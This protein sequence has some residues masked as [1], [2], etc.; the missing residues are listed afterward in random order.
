MNGQATIRPSSTL[1]T[2]FSP[3]NILTELR[4]L[5]VP[6]VIAAVLYR[7]FGLA[8]LLVVAAGISDG[9]DGWLA[10]HFRRTSKLGEYLDP[11]ADKALVS[12]LFIALALIGG[13]PWLLTILVFTRDLSILVAAL[14]VFLA[15]GF[16]DFRPTLMGKVNTVAEIATIFLALLNQVYAAAWSIGLER[17][18]WGVVFAFAYASGIH[19]AF[20]CA[21]RY[22][23]SHS[24]A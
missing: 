7:A 5:C 3:A 13:L 11:I 1:G 23:R 6:I 19:Y 16:R 17:L 24:P 2:F 14:W 10:R 18:G 20:T 4:L 9:V 22:H 21:A 12:S 8:L 15:T